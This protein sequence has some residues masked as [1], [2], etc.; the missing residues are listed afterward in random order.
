MCPLKEK[1]ILGSS[2]LSTPHLSIP[3][4]LMWVRLSQGFFL[5][6]AYTKDCPEPGANSQV[7]SWTL[8]QENRPGTQKDLLKAP[9]Y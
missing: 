7:Q 3:E 4:A 8:Q 5:F 2:E 9:T 1:P 6:S